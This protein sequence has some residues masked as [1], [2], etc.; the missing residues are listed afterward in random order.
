M[1][2]QMTVPE[3]CLTKLILYYDKLDFIVTVVTILSIF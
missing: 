2:R 1:D 3:I